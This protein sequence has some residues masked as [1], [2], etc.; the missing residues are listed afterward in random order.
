MEEWTNINKKII[1]KDGEGFYFRDKSGRKFLDGIANMWCNVW[2]FSENEVLLSMKKQIDSIPH[3]T[4]FGLGNE[5]SIIFSNEFLKIAK[6][7]DKIFFTDNGS[8][9]IEAA[10][11]ISIQYWK[12][13]GN[14]NKKKFLSLKDGYHGDTIGAMSVGYVDKYFNNFK[15]LLI[16]CKKLPKPF[17]NKENEKDN[18]EE[19]I[20]ISEKIINE[21]CENTSALI[22]ESGA[23][24]A[25]G[26]LIYPDH[27]QKKIKE[28]CKKYD[29]LLILDEIATGFGRLGN[30]IEYIHQESIPD[31]VCY[32]KALTG[33]YFPLA[34][35]LTSNK[36]FAEFN[37]K[38]HDQKHLYHGH[39]FT[40]HPIGCAAATANLKMYKKKKLLRK[41][42]KNSNLIKKRII[43]F[44]KFSITKNIRSK[45]L[46]G[47][48][49]LYY[50]KKPVN[51]VD[52][53]PIN[54]FVMKESIKEGIFLRSLGNTII[55]IPPIAM[56]TISLN[57]IIETQLNIVKK[58]E[59]KVKLT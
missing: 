39:T 53:M 7:M 31:I 29:I 5:K 11:K 12:N 43:E 50:K 36:I 4:L 13:K 33:G 14:N 41:I 51:M 42:E 21:N 23:Q 32:G 25:G 58:I 24:I 37:G 34:I 47:G 40:G 22:M 46:L 48:I 15:H 6:G 57:K 17:T 10:L 28:I 18:I 59:N 8:S 30:I 9:A 44:E 56:D 49:D 26:V 54:F 2:G 27:Y 45:G 52:N 3:S 35:T 20:E 38:Y 16:K 1:I 19:I 55:L